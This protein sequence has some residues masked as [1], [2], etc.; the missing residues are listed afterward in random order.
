MCTCLCG[1]G[2][3]CGGG[4]VELYYKDLKTPAIETYLALVHS[5]F[6]TNTF[7]SVL[8]P[9][10]TDEVDFFYLITNTTLAKSRGRQG[11]RVLVARVSKLNA[12]TYKLNQSR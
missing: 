9:S 8:E 11:G 5:R 1:Y 7:P 10:P 12:C 6:S 3:S 2:W 4:Q